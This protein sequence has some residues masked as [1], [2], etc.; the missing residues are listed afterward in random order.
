[1]ASERRWKASSR[2]AELERNIMNTKSD[3][4]MG[5]HSTGVKRKTLELSYLD[6]NPGQA[7]H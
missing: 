5:Q 1:M 3:W 6:S 4:P 2:R 7:M